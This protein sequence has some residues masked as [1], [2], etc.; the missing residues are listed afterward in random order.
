MGDSVH[1]PAVRLFEGEHFFKDLPEQYGFF[2]P[3]GLRRVS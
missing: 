2:D 1:E 3:D